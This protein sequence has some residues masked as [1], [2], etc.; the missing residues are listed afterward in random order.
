V[1]K[2]SNSARILAL[3]GLMSLV[4]CLFYWYGQLL[5]S[6]RFGMLVPALLTAPLLLPLPGLIRGRAYTYAWTSLLTL[7]YLTWILT[8]LL[9]N[10]A[11]RTAAYPA[12]FSALMLF[13]G[14]L[15]FVRLDKREREARANPTPAP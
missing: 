3:A 9:A 7:L 14:C 8:E 6:H 15:L 13:T 1:R 2:L 4:A 12:F 11:S 10:P 5:P